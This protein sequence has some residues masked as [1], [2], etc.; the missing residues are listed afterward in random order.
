MSQS[1]TAKH[2]AAALQLAAAARR[3]AS[4]ERGS[5]ALHDLDQLLS[6]G[7]CSLDADNQQAIFTLLQGVWGSYTGTALDAIRDQLPSVPSEGG[8]PND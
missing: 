6:N 4:S 8:S 1:D 7:G 5:Q 2:E 3:L